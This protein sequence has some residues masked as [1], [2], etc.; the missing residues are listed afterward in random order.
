[1]HKLY[2]AALLHDEPTEMIEKVGKNVGCPAASVGPAFKSKV[3]AVVGCEVVVP[4]FAFPINSSSVRIFE[5]TAPCTPQ[6]DAGVT[7]WTL[8]VHEMITVM[9]RVQGES[10][11]GKST[12]LAGAGEQHSTEGL[13]RQH[14]PALTLH[15]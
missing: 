8:V 5:R 1:M 15:T 14:S 2:A 10:Q 11:Q 13:H 6:R 12:G 9:T 7:G 3:H 4:R